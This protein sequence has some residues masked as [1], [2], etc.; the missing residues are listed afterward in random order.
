MK[1]P[2]RMLAV[3]L[4]FLMLASTG[5]MYKMYYVTTLREGVK[6]GTLTVVLFATSLIIAWIVQKLNV[7]PVRKD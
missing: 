1:K 3:F 6:L 5:T 2:Y 7:K 4:F